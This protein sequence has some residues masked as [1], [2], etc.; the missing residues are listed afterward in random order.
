MGAATMVR[1]RKAI[2]RSNISIEQSVK[3]VDKGARHG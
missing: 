2:L 1:S 3:V